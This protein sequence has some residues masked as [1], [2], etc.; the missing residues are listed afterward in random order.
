MAD[1]IQLKTPSHNELD[2]GAEL[3]LVTNE[4]RE[5]KEKRENRKK[6]KGKREEE[7]MEEKV[8]IMLKERYLMSYL[9]G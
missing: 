6:E 1:F 5:K 9:A 8:I 3:E 2:E 7:E 4:E